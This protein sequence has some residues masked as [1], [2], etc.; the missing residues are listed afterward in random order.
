MFVS[1]TASYNTNLPHTS[2]WAEA[3]RPFSARQPMNIMMELHIVKI[4][5]ISLNEV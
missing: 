2:Q 3:G 4:N 5:C 1:E